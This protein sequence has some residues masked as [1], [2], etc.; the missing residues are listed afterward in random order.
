MSRE[1]PNECVCDQLPS[2]RKDPYAQE[3]KAASEQESGKGRIDRSSTFCSVTEPTL[4]HS[5]T[6]SQEV[7]LVW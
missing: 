7:R 2:L 6:S 5:C 3:E 1:G 4:Q